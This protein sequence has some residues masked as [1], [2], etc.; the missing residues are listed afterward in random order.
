MGRINKS[1]SLTSRGLHYKLRV[2]FSLMSVIPLLVCVYLFFIYNPY[3]AKIPFSDLQIIISLLICVVI[4]GTGFLLAKQIVDPIV[5]ISSEVKNIANGNFN[6]TIE[7]YRED[8]IGDLSSALNQ[9]TRHIRDN[10][11]ELRSYGERTKQ[12]NSEINKR[13]VV[14]SGLL[15]ISNLITQ[16]ASLTEVFEVSIS[17]LL[18]LKSSTWVILIMKNDENNSFK[19][20]SQQGIS[21]ALQESLEKDGARKIFDGILLNKN[22]WLITKG[23]N[24]TK[25]EQLRE[26]FGTDHAVFMPVFRHARI[27]GFLGVGNSHSEIEYTNDDLE[28]LQVFAKQVSIAIENDYLANRLQKLEIKDALTS[29]YNKSF[30]IS[31]LDE[32]IKRAMIYQRPC[33]FVLFAIDNFNEFLNSFGQL[34]GEEVLK[35]VSRII[36]KSCREIDRVARYGDSDFGVILPEKNKKQS[37]SVAEEIRKKILEFF[38][39]EEKWKKHLTISMAVSE[40]PIDGACAKDL[41]EK[42]EK[43]LKSAKQEK[44][45]AKS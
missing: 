8:E 37:V 40:N 10:M 34:A 14:L 27:I 16:G 29:L 23:S 11:D 15:Q 26:M 28:L 4:A 21:D 3:I 19:I 18:Q 5:T 17:K 31:R 38:N 42:A 43:V 45:A 6:K 30:I 22:G 25:S 39:Q 9:I 13:V 35:K 20:C 32:E 12:I 24:D 44:D 1:L 41:V 36:E 33:A 2:A 7:I